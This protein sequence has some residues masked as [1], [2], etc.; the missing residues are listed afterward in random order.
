[1]GG[2]IITTEGNR[3]SYHTNSGHSKLLQRMCIAQGYQLLPSSNYCPTGAQYSN[4]Q[5]YIHWRLHKH[6]RDPWMYVIIY[7]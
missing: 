1:M 7:N 5:A 4:L 6:A 2:L 3:L